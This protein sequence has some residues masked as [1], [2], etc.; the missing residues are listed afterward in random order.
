MKT[1]SR[2][3]IILLAALTVVGATWVVGT[4]GSS[5]SSTGVEQQGDFDGDE[6]RPLPPGGEAGFDRDGSQFLRVGGWL[7][8]LKT[9]VPMTI[10]IAVVTLATNLSKRHRRAQQTNAAIP[11]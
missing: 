11:V 8:F 4:Q 7:G 9:L 6:G 2:I 10:V 5:D 3:L 1:M